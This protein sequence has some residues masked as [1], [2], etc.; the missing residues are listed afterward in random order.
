MLQLS[1]IMTKAFRLTLF[2]LVEVQCVLYSILANRD[3]IMNYIY[4][5]EKESY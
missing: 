2:M 3:N 5:I 1:G 4:F